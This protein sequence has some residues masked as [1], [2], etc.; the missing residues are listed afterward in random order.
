MSATLAP[1]LPRL[2]RRLTRVAVLIGSLAV[3]TLQAA[4]F[5]VATNGNDNNPGTQ[6]QPFLTVA[7]GV[8]SAF[9]G[10]TIILGAG[11]F[12]ASSRL[13]LRAGVNLQGQGPTTSI[14]QTTA[15]DFGIYMN[16]T[17]HDTTGQTLQNFGL[18]PAVLRSGTGVGIEMR[19]RSNVV[20]H[21]LRI[22]GF[23][24]SGL[25][26]KS[27]DTTTAPSFYLAG[28]VIRNSTFINTGSRTSTDEGL[29]AVMIKGLEGALIHGNTINEDLGF[30]LKF[31]G[32]GWF[33]G[34]K[35]YSNTINTA[36][37]FPGVWKSGCSIELW[38]LYDDCEIYDNTLNQWT[39]FVR[40]DKGNGT[41]AAR[42]YR[43]TVTFSTANP[44]K[45]AFEINLSDVE[46]FD[47]VAVRAKIGVVTFEGGAVRT[48]VV[49]RDNVF[50]WPTGSG[51][52]S[53][54]YMDQRNLG[55]A[56]GWR[57]Y[58]NVFDGYVYGLRIS[59][60]GAGVHDLRFRNNVVARSTHLVEIRNVGSA[61]NVS[62]LLVTHNGAHCTGATINNLIGAAITANNNLVY[63]SVGG[64]GLTLSGARPDP[65]YVPLA[66]SPL[67][68]AG[69]NVG[70]AYSGLAP[71]IG[72]FEV[73]G[74]QLIDFETGEGY[75]N[76]N[77]G[78]QPA[79]AAVTWSGSGNGLVVQSATAYSGARAIRS[80]N[81]ASTQ[82]FAYNPTN[83]TG[84]VFPANLDNAT[85]NADK[86]R[87]SFRYAYQT[88]NT[89]SGTNFIEQYFGSSG[90]A[91]CVAQMNWKANGQLQLV[92]GGGT[93]IIASNPVLNQF[94][95]VELEADYQALTVRALVN[96]VV[97]GTYPFKANPKDDT[98]AFRVP[99]S[100]VHQTVVIDQVN[101]EVIP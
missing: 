78:G 15:S 81:P 39:S 35:V 91:T 45:E 62:G 10:D 44:V 85:G 38:N 27:Q 76:G 54:V 67:I 4:T 5:Y 87:L 69:I 30:G 7:K 97:Q 13:N 79:S 26:I 93:V 63:S 41:W 90:A 19:Q 49:V 98:L 37:F 51:G 56:N 31:W 83:G 77:L 99:T 28:I 11:T 14:I 52:T 6:S 89:G 36:D 94:N 21:N 59:P 43:N 16:S 18:R 72:L 48:N 84:G 24:T 57:V 46:L 34:I 71:D 20:F 82:T 53:G 8:Q 66:N 3:A 9:A 32:G 92:H 61:S 29:G 95:L 100:S 50:Y 74:G 42:I 33:K 65:Y 40:G 1:A 25:W 17:S 80:Q 22:E 68:D 23:T 12:P 101:W 73:V 47:N 70:Y 86:V 55:G 64:L 96:G 60:N 58:H 75:A 2:A 88:L